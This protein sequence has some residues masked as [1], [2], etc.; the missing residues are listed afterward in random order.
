MYWKNWWRPRQDT[1][2]LD[3]LT[4]KYLP[5]IKN[6]YQASLAYHNNE[7]YMGGSVIFLVL[8]LL[9]SAYIGW[10][11]SEES[12]LV[13]P[14]EHTLLFAAFVL[15]LAGFLFFTEKFFNTRVSNFTKE[16]A[17]RWRTFFNETLEP[18][19]MITH[20]LNWTSKLTD[21]EYTVVDE[22][23]TNSIPHHIAATLRK[24]AYD[25][26]VD[27]MREVQKVEKS[28]DQVERRK[29]DRI[30]L[31]LISYIMMSEN[32]T[33]EDLRA[34]IYRDAKVRAS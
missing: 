23:C 5:N 11:C 19:G 16:V 17:L 22:S 32:V 4:H 9:V 3:N 1:A 2:Y 26:A 15:L 29:H 28:N 10:I 13:L 6:G 25:R 34:Q 20:L 31:P 27:V 8:T 18:S 30:L 14:K 12:I 7:G 24:L 33:Y 21:S